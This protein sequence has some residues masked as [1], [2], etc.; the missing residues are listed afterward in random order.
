MLSN[1]RAYFNKVA[2]MLTAVA[3]VRTIFGQT[4]Q[5]PGSKAG[6]AGNP[7]GAANRVHNGIYYFPGIGSNSGYPREDHVLVTDPF[8]KHVTRTME[9]LKKS[10]ERAGC[11]MDSILHLEVFVCLPHSDSVPMP[12][13]KARFDAYSA[14]YQT[15]NKIYGSFFSAGRA[16]SRAYMAVDWIPGDSLVEIVGSARVV[17]PPA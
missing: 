9:S 10:L 14:Q 12:T 1:R 7:A 6:G 2:T 15:L 5:A 8:E 16:P 17:T 3:G 13:G 11:S 4:P